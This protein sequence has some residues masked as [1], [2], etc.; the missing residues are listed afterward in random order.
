MINTSAPPSIS[1]WA[2]SLNVSTRRSKL[3]LPRLGS[4]LPGRKPLG[5][6]EPAT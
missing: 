4:S 5:P 1:P 3:M 2:C 6:I